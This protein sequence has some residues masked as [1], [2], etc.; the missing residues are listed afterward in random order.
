MPARLVWTPQARADLID[1][2]LTIGAEQPSAADRYLARMEHKAQLLADQ[3]RLGAR[4]PDIH[5]AARMLV[6]SPFVLLYETEPDTDDGPIEIVEIVRV[7]D[8]R[9]DLRSLLPE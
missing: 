2:Y 4:R 9:R 8:G 1:I 5:P 6:E 7:V 3:P